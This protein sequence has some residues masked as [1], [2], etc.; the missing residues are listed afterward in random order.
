MVEFIGKKGI[1]D[2]N[3]I[4]LSKLKKPYP[5]DFSI[6]EIVR[7]EKRT[8]LFL[9][10]HLNRLFRSFILEELSVDESAEDIERM[11]NKLIR[12]NGIDK[13]KIKFV[14]YFPEFPKSENYHFF[15]YYTEALFPG[16]EEYNGGVDVGLC[17]A[18]RNDPNAKVLNTDAR[19]KAN[20]K[21]EDE[22][23]FEV[24]L[25]DNEGYV[26]EGSRS[27]VFFISEGTLIT[28]PDEAV[29]Q[30]IAR[31]NVLEISDRHNFAVHIRKVHRTELEQM[32]SVFLTGTSLKVL[33][34]RRVENLQFD[35]SSEI[36]KFLGDQYDKKIADYIKMAGKLIK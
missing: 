11:V 13:G 12:T 30:G 6:Y 28:P 10:D 26:W 17:T 32:Q 22:N 2:G 14:F 33:P 19:K 15:I 18:I 23:V 5:G 34:V 25:V 31:K 36:L 9:E 7:I 27:N 29:L 20:Q 4:D 21:I 1:F 24:L 35:V 8:A 16:L 3:L